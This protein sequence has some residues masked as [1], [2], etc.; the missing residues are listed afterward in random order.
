MAITW[1]WEVRLD[2]KTCL[3]GVYS[4]PDTTWTLPFTDT[5][6]NR[7]V[8]GSDFGSAQGTILTPDSN[9]G[10]SV[11]IAGDYSAGCCMLGRTYDFSLELTRPFKRRPDNT[12]NLDT[13]TTI[14]KVIAAYHSSGP[15]TIRGSYDETGIDDRSLTF[16][17]DDDSLSGATVKTLESWLTGPADE[18]TIY[19]ESTSPKPVIIPTIDIQCDHESRR[20]DRY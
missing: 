6:I 12:V 13:F 1:P 16:T 19:I 9:D 17:Q 2:R 8:L 5:T 20:G 10:T 15:F 11:V 14:E 4:D 18:L 7:I 3:A